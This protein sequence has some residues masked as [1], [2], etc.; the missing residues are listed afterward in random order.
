MWYIASID[1]EWVSLLGFSASALKCKARDEWNGQS[2]RHQFD[3]LKLIVDNNRFLILSGWHI[4]NL[5]S[6]KISLCLKRLG[7][8]WTRVF[9]HKIVL[10]ET[11]VDPDK[12]L[13][14]G[15]KH[16]IGFI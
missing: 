14:Q 16:Q 10:V 12:F 9:G 7:D 1:N 5:A 13:G 8:D 3:R 4:Q 15:T 2:Y 6:R 11:L